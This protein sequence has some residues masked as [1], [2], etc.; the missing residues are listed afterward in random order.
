MAAQHTEAKSTADPLGALH[1][2]RWRAI[3]QAGDVIPS[4]PM[5]MLPCDEGLIPGV[6][7]THLPSKPANIWQI[8]CQVLVR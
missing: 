7:V 6:H 3:V 2:H 5:V 4:F 1:R 8:L